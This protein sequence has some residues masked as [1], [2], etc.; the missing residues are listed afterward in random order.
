MMVTVASAV[1][2]V[3]AVIGLAI[4]EANIRPALVS[5]IKKEL[6]DEDH[7]TWFTERMTETLTRA[8]PETL[9]K[10]SADKEF[11]DLIRAVFREELSG[12]D[13]ARLDEIEST[14]G[15]VLDLFQFPTRVSQI[16][17]FVTNRVDAIYFFELYDRRPLQVFATPGISDAPDLSGVAVSE[18][19]ARFYAARDQVITIEI[20]PSAGS[21]WR[22]AIDRGDATLRVNVAGRDIVTNDFAE[23]D[24]TCD[25]RKTLG[26]RPA[27]LFKIRSNPS[28]S[29]ALSDPKDQ[30]QGGYQLDITIVARKGD[31]EC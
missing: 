6:N 24:I 15:T 31:K 13:I 18:L 23:S 11:R 1:I 9:A 28:F 8:D 30:P 29:A 25:V 4:W 27:N 14:G 26:T 12:G 7:R 20:R 22:D 2:A 19:S 21:D 5:E 3:L 16:K 10:L 17:D